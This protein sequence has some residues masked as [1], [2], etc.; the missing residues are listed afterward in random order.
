M[1]TKKNFSRHKIVASAATISLVVIA[2]ITGCSTRGEQSKV[3]DESAPNV[4]ITTAKGSGQKNTEGS[5]E[6]KSPRL[7]TGTI[8]V[9]TINVPKTLTRPTR[10]S[11]RVRMGSASRAEDFLCTFMTNYSVVLNADFDATLNVFKHRAA[12]M[13]ADWIAITKHSEVVAGTEAMN[14][15][16]IYVVDGSSIFD[17]YSTLTKIEGD[18]YD[19]K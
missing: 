5:L 12:R 15:Q 6:P 11:Q 1:I 13:G 3:V 8:S 17:E 18:I 2:G 7:A 9:P 19:C 4:P 10:F 14:Q 16:T